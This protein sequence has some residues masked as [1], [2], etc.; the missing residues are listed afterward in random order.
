MSIYTKFGKLFNKIPSIN[1]DGT[2]D[3]PLKSG[4]AKHY[5]YI[6][7]ATL[8]KIVKPIFTANGLGFYQPVTL[9]TDAQGKMTLGAVKTIIFDCET[10]ETMEAGT[11]PFVVTGDPQA[12]GSAIT[13]ARRYGLSSVLGIYPD[14][15]DDGAYARDYSHKPP[16]QPQ[17]NGITA[18]IAQNLTNM[19]KEHNVNL[20]QLASQI[21]GHKITRLRELTTD[22]AQKIALQLEGVE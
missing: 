6:N 4:G 8:L 1:P 3:I 16:E 20:L 11:Y 2:A 7:L 12:N 18:D 19:A 5:N 21:K 22:V 14:K 17:A 13:Y 15:D 10:G 9:E